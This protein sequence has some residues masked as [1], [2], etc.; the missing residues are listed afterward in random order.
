MII[1]MKSGATEE[2]IGGVTE[3]LKKHG[4]GIHLSK[5]VERTVIGAIG[6]KSAIELETLAML[7][8]VSEIV[9]I[10]KPY[11]L[12]SREFKQED[13]VVKLNDKVSVGAKLP[14][15][16]M[17]GPCSVESR[18]QMIEIARA[19]KSS[20]ANALRGGA[21][22][23][24]T[25]PYSFQGLGEEGLK[26]LAEARKETGLPVV[27]EVVDPR[28]VP[29]IVKYADV[30]QIGARNM[31]NFVLLREV[32]KTGKPVLLKRGPAS[33]VEELLMS[34]E[35]ILSEG[36]RNVMLCERGIRTIENYT[37]NTLDLSAVPVIK[38]LSH[39]PVVVDPSHGTGRW[40]LVTSMA[41]AAV[42]AG[43]DGLIIEVHSHP[44]E[45]LS[46]GPQS[47]KPDTFAELMSKLKLV[48]QAVSR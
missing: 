7:P 25:S 18:E 40:D 43:C 33:T 31:Q 1:I 35:Y 2:Q 44:D 22:K 45:A 29:L 48:A 8:G 20:G 32:G 16:V 26:I 46:D 30:L 11:K 12:V 21:F 36:N 3:K 34:A 42:A 5:G 47:L 39:L 17:A 27:T 9:P 4:F 10:R 41:L 6:D 23:P 28:D 24:R 13:S 37:R 38:K 19:V 15:C 14:I